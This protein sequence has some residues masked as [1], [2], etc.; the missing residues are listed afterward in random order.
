M[1]TLNSGTHV[2]AEHGQLS[3]AVAFPKEAP[4]LAA[5]L[6][7]LV[8]F[9]IELVLVLLVLAI[10]H[11]GHVPMS[12]A[13]IPVLIVVQVVLALGLAFPIATVSVFFHDLEHAL[14]ILVTSLFYISP[15]FYPA[16][17]VPEAWRSLYMAS[18]LAQV[19]TLF[20]TVVYAG[21][22]PTPAALLLVSAMSI[23]LFIIG[24]GIFNRYQ[25]LFAELV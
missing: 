25:H 22:M 4:I 21:Q 9:T 8:E 19:L 20:H 18:P 5:A 7:R 1:L 14:P 3:R 10:F 11:H 15:V 17:M 24:Y 13:V 2:L 23:V 16:T 12:F 6:S